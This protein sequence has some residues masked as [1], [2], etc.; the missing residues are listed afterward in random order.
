[1]PLLAASIDDSSLWW[2][3]RG[4]TLD[5]RLTRRLDLHGVVEAT[6]HFQA[7]YD[8]EDQFDYVYL[9]ASRDGGATWQVLPGR[10][11]ADDSATG[12][13]YG[14][15][16]TASSGSGWIDEE[17]DLN[18]YAGGDVLLRFEYVT[19]QSYNGQGFAFRN[20]RL[21]QAGIDEP[22]AVDGPWNAEG[23]VRVDAPVPEQWNLRLVR[24]TPRGIL[25]DPVPVNADGTAT[26]EL[27][28][29]AVR[30]TLVVAPTAP[31]TLLPG[32]YSLTLR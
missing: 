29:T 32:T 12:N 24:W 6:L 16:W 20:V 11:A 27:D 15:G 3:N 22:G 9:S 19:D 21:P 14:A 18:A 7:W 25:V 30:S 2:S 1:V 28:A 5:S 23:W 17:V 8:L 31:R 10:R 26:F 4:D 13:H